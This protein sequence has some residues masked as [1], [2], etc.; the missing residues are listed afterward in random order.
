MTR[1]FTATLLISIALSSH[2]ATAQQ[3]TLSKKSTSELHR[4]LSEFVRQGQIPAVEAVI[5]GKDSVLYR[6]MFGKR[7]AGEDI[8][9]QGGDL[10]DVASMTKPV[11]AVAAMIL[12]DEGK[13]DLNDPVAKYFPAFEHL[14]VITS[15]DRSDTTYVSTAPKNPLTIHH[16]LTHTSGMGYP[17]F[18]EPLQMLWD[19]WQFGEF[20]FVYDYM[21]FPLLYEP[22]MDW[23]YG[24]SAQ[25]LGSVIEEVSGQRLDEFFQGRIFAP[26][27]MNNTFFKI[28]EDKLDRR[29]TVQV[30]DD[31]KWIEQPLV[32]GQEPLIIGDATLVSTAMDYARFLQM[33]LNGGTLAGKKILSNHSVD[34]MTR[35]QIG[36]VVVHE[37]FNGFPKGAGRDKFGYGFRIST[38]D[39]N[40]LQ[41]RS[42]GSYSWAGS[43]NTFFW[44]DPKREFAAVLFMHFLPFHQTNALMVYEDFERQVYAGL[45]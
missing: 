43:N 16:L 41:H 42:A 32:D 37:L 33:L 36:N 7:N 18:Y 26:L 1:L 8:D 29:V 6:G 25:V 35:N 23:S 4:L 13:L 45:D 3:A 2:I 14:E 21:K 44:V 22:G 20:Q 27:R 5:V 34:L 39:S 30:R 31:G 9:L 28:P 12:H 10:F 38:P 15:F 40:S 17:Y 24:I 11:T 19:K